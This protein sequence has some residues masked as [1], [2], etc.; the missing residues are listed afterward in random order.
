MAWCRRRGTGQAHSGPVR[1]GWCPSPTLVGGAGNR[2]T[3]R[4]LVR[5][6]VVRLV[7]RGHERARHRLPAAIGP[8]DVYPTRRVGRVATRWRSVATGGTQQDLWPW[9]WL[10]EDRPEVTACEG[11]AS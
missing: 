11:D 4:A 3:R 9:T 7:H 5:R 10:V 2:R 8:P 6:H 1:A